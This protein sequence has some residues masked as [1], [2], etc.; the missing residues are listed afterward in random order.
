MFS[1]KITN[2]ARFLKM[3]LD[4]QL[5]YFHLGMAADDD[6][7]V[8]AYPVLKTTGSNE[9]NLKVLVAKGLVKIL[10]EDLVLFITDWQE[11]NLI[12][13]DRKVD[14]IYKNLLLQMVPDVDLI[15]AKPRADTGKLPGGMS[16]DGLRTAHG[17]HKVSKGKVSKVKQSLSLVSGVQEPQKPSFQNSTLETKPSENLTEESLPERIN[18]IIVFWN[19]LDTSKV[20]NVTNPK[21]TTTLKKLLP[22]CNGITE[23]IEKSFGKLS[24][25]SA[26]DFERATKNYVKE[27]LNR[28]PKNDYANHRFSFYEFFK[29]ENGFIKFLNK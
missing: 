25:Y 14:S 11:H 4:S 17:P 10:N 18:T 24:G 9:D 15:E 21:N 26:E 8:E 27:I 22:R 12:R 2:S 1:D 29:Q 13:A 16:V 28:D 20:L 5:L 6:G 3:P 19:S 23:P 7:I